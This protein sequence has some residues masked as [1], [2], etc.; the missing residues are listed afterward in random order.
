MQQEIFKVI[1]KELNVSK[2]INY[3]VIT[4]I[5]FFPLRIGKYDYSKL[6]PRTSIWKRE[7]HKSICKNVEFIVLW[8]K[9][10]DSSLSMTSYP[11]GEII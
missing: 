3:P 9:R 8:N 7:S 2:A 4:L 11:N 1:M 10:R 6:C 5:Q